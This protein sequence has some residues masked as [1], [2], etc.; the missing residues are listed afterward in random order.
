MKSLAHPEW[1]YVGTPWEW[2]GF[3]KADDRPRAIYA[4]D[5]KDYYGPEAVKMAIR[6]LEAVYQKQNFGPE[7]D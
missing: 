2:R 3:G 1:P 6:D 4:G 5:D 7:L